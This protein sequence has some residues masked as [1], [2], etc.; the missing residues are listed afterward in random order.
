MPQAPYNDAGDQKDGPNKQVCSPNVTWKVVVGHADHPDG[1]QQ[2]HHDAQ[3]SNGKHYK[4]DADDAEH[5]VRSFG[6]YLVDDRFQLVDDLG[7]PVCV[8]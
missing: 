3:P 4:K 5:G 6:L 1:E 8:V 7:S 2:Q